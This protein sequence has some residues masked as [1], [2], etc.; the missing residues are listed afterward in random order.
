M[1]GNWIIFTSL[2]YDKKPDRS[3]HPSMWNSRGKIKS[4]IPREQNYG[5][6]LVKNG[7]TVFSKLMQKISLSVSGEQ[8]SKCSAWCLPFSEFYILSIF[9]SCYFNEIYFPFCL[10]QMFH[11]FWTNN[12]DFYWSLALQFSCI[13]VRFSEGSFL[14]TVA[15]DQFQ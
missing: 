2:Q 12:F 13:T 14:F 15:S 7:K 10:G 1:E 5:A 8:A 3:I 6:W 11:G 9:L 4:A